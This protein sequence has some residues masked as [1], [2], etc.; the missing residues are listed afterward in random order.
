MKQYGLLRFVVAMALLPWAAIDARSALP[1]QATLRQWIQEMKVSDRGP[2]QRIRWFCRDGTVWPARPYPC[3]ERGGG[4]QHGEWTAQ[5]KQLRDNGYYIANIFAEIE[6]QRRSWSLER[7]TEYHHILLERF[8]FNI[9]DGWILRRAQFYRG[10]LQAEDETRGARRALLSLIRSRDWVEKAY[11]PLRTGV[12]LVPHAKETASVVQV[13]QLSASLSGR[14]ARFQSLRNKIHVAPEA[15][16]AG[17]VRDYAAALNNQALA[18]PYIRLAAMI[19]G[20]YGGS[21]LFVPLSRV[22]RDANSA[23]A[24]A[25]R[26]GLTTLRAD[27]NALTRF[28]VT[29]DLMAAIRENLPQLIGSES[30]LETLD[31]SLLLERE[32]FA[33]GTVLRNQLLLAT[34]GQRLSWLRASAKA[35]YGAGLMTSRQWQELEQVFKPLATGQVG[36]GQY[37]D[38]LNYLAR[39]TG[40]GSQ[41]MRYFFYDAMAE[42]ARIEPLAMLF[43]QDQLRASPL[44]FFAEVLNS[45]LLDANRLAGVRSS[46][47]GDDVGAGL[48]SLNPGLAKGVLRLAQDSVST[49]HFSRDGIYLLPETV[50][51]LP[52]VAGIIT[53][54]EGNPLSHVQLL[55]R[56]LGIPNVAIDEPLIPNLSRYEG[57]RVV[58]AVSA[59]GAVQLSLD[60]GSAMVPAVSQSDVL[61]RPDLNK[62]DLAFQEFVPLSALRSSDSGRIVGPKAAKL[63][64]LYHHYPEAVADGLAIPFG[65]FRG[66]LEKIMPGTDQTVFNWMVGQYYKIAAMPLG[67]AERESYTEGFR[68]RLQVQIEKLD[69]GFEFRRRLRSAM[70]R[71]FGP[72]GSYGVFVRSDTNVEDLPGFTGA[73]LNL[74]VPNVVGFENIVNAIPQV[75]A[76]PFTERAFAWRQARMEQPEHVYPAVLLMRSVPVEK[77]GV[78]VTQD[79]DS[80]APGWLSIAINEGVGGAVDGQAA[81]S[82]RV[83]TADGQVRLLAAAT[84]T[85][86]RI[87]LP[88]GGVSKVPVTGSEFVLQKNEIQQLIA[89]ARDLPDRLP[90]LTDE[91]GKP[92]AADIEFGFLNGQLKLF[93]I[94]PFLESKQA[95]RSDYLATLDS[96]EAGSRDSMVSLEEIPSDHKF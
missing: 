44:F 27:D 49:G 6:R 68:N 84:A 46:L 42:F 19:D 30:K 96:G 48:R 18:A 53:A 54:G 10:A 29:A 92:A 75:W 14:D 59:G 43:I 28:Q 87:L 32:H 57:R 21:D 52:P 31:A 17:R 88:Q 47:F 63:G 55:A 56:N 23:L 83:N 9:D 3:D 33:A 61:I 69:P 26:A 50:A 90:P 58:L 82:I 1:D 86:R 40:W 91:E 64:E 37:R 2:F 94:R 15:S 81:E 95:R 78:M 73:G 62:L 16:D 76:S 20:I 25:I 11:V 65:V 85:Q 35:A 93:Q 12:R 8:L 66:Y 22:Q 71:V 13:R 89:L 70:D 72:D 67:S 24:D 36:L 4:V 38:G 51:D 80:G 39:A 60:D 79:I 5:V 77:S 7:A 34:R 74:T 41:T 45:L